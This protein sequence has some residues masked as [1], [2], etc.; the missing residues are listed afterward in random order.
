MMDNREAKELLTKKL[1]EYR[2]FSYASLV[3]KLGDIDCLE[4]TGQ[5]GAEYHIEVQFLWDGKPDGDV[6]VMA[7]IDDGGLRA[8]IPLCE[9]FIMTPGGEFVGE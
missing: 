2:S 5:S 9:D 8:F 3:A 6:R 1:A 7:G 4:V